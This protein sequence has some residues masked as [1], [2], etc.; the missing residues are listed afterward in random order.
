VRPYRPTLPGRDQE[1]F[2]QAVRRKE[3]S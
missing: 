2:Y 1:P 3:G